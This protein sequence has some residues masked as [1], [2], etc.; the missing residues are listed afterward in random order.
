MLKALFLNDEGRLPVPHRFIFIERTTFYVSCD[1][2]LD[3]MSSPPKNPVI[4]SLIVSILD[5]SLEEDP[6]ARDLDAVFLP[7]DDLAAVLRLLALFA[8]P[9]LLP[10]AFLAAVEPLLPAADFFVAVRFVV[11]LA[12]AAL[13][14]VDFFAVLRLAFVLAAPFLPAA[15][16]FAVVLRPVLLFLAVL[17]FAVLLLAAVLFLAPVLFLAAVLFLAVDAF[18]AV[19]AFFVVLRF[20][21]VLAAPFLPAADFLAAVPP[22]LD[23][24]LRPAVLF[25][26][27]LAFFVDFDRVFFFDALPASPDCVPSFISFSAIILISP[28]LINFLVGA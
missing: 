3:S 24:A 14:A 26:A 17:F 21:F 1:C 12:L 19:P 6:F 7:A 25:L 16:F 11:F 5:L 15:A 27:V 23:P 13:P 2:S 28:S 22:F 10:A 18:L 9:P 8:F 20:A 4:A